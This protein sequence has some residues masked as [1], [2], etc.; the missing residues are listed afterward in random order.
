MKKILI[1][2]SLLAL[3]IMVSLSSAK[4]SKASEPILG[5]IKLFAGNFAPRGYAFCDGQLLSISGNEALFSLLVIY[6]GG[7]GMTTF[8]L[9]DLRGRAP[10]HIGQGT[11]LSNR[12]MIGDKSGAEGVA[13][14]SA[15]LPV[16]THVPIAGEFVD[17]GSP[18]GNTWGGKRCIDQFSTQSPDVPMYSNAIDISGDGQSH[19]NMPPFIAVHYIIALQGLYPS[20]P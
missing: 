5:E 8:G 18:L 9:P 7:D 10:I 1:K 11:G 6:Y 15:Q 16:H 17:E 3:I 20:R 4:V 19:N 13:L 14:S 2:C 12:P